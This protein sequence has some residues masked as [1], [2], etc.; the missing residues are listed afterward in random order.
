[1]NE[2]ILDYKKQFD[3]IILNLKN[4][5]SERIFN[6]EKAFEL[7]EHLHEGQT[8][9]SGEKY[10]THPVAVASYLEKLDFDADVISAALLHDV[11]EDCGYSVKDIEQNF[12]KSIAQIVDAVSAYT[13]EDY[14]Y[15]Q[16]IVYDNADFLKLSLEGKTYHK[17]YNIGKENRF[18]F[19]IKFADRLHNLITIGSMLDYKRQEKVKET[20][21]WILPICEI[22]K[23]SYFYYHIKSEC[24]KISNEKR[25]ANFLEEYNRLTNLLK[26]VN[27]ELK[28]DLFQL[29]SSFIAKNKLKD[30]LFKIEI[31]PITEEQIFDDITAKLQMK[32]LTQIK[33]NHLL[34]VPMHDIFLIV[35]DVQTPN[36]LTN[37]LFEMLEDKQFN[38]RLKIADFVVD[39]KFNVSYFVVEDND[40]NK[41]RLTMLYYADY[42]KLLDGTT[43]G[44]MVE[45]IDAD[46]FSKVDTNYINVKT[47]NNEVVKMPAGS[48]VLDFAFK[49]HNDIGFSFKYALINDSPNHMPQ[50]TKL[51]EGDKIQIFCETDQAT[52]QNI[53]VAQIKWLAYVYT[54]YAKRI[55]I[56]YFEKKF[57]NK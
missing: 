14:T 31:I 18:A 20:E 36:N 48:T 27:E 22:L 24:F 15:E 13:K 33:P 49:I 12:N 46:S 38:S 56:R 43:E 37:L 16:D 5:K 23:T 39:E 47:R 25:I 29:T 54:E 42:L 34:S 35:N 30:T 21:K 4:K 28:D 57:E 11:V 9:K 41:Y 3:Q 17:L 8:R 7:A 2:N 45:Y 55:L 50:Y 51:T 26:T 6:V 1:M 53:Y 32:S 44:T 52:N 40:K 10:I 19:Y